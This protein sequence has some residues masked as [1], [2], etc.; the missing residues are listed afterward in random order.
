MVTKNV[1]KSHKIVYYLQLNMKQRIIYLALL[2]LTCSAAFAQSDDAKALQCAAE[3]FSQK[4]HNNG[5][6]R[7]VKKLSH[8]HV[9]KSGDNQFVVVGSDKS[10]R[11]KVIAYSLCNTAGEM[12]DAMIWWLENVNAALEHG[13]TI[14]SVVPGAL[15]PE[16]APLIQTKWNQSAPFNNACPIYI[17]S[18]GTQAPSLTGCVATAMAQVMYYHR[19]PAQYGNGTKT[20]TVHHGDGS[21]STVTVNFATTSFD[22]DN[23]LTDYSNGYNAE[24]ADAVAQLML[25]CGVAANTT[26][27]STSSSALSSNTVYGLKRYLGFENGDYYSNKES[28]PAEEWLRDIYKNISDSF[29]VIYGG[30]NSSNGVHEFV[31]DGYDQNGLV[32]VNWGWGGN[33]DGFFNI[34]LLNPYSS[35]TAGYSNEQFKMVNIYPEN[36]DLENVIEVETPGTLSTLLPE[37]YDKLYPEIKIKGALNSDDVAWIRHL[38]QNVTKTFDFSESSIVEGGEPYFGNLVTVANEFPAH[39][40]DGLSINSI[41]LPQSITAIGDSAFANNV[42]LKNVEIPVGVK[43]IGIGSFA[44]CSGITSFT[45]PSVIETLGDGAFAGCTGI[46]SIAIPVGIERLSDNL[47][48]DCTKLSEVSLSANIKDI[49]DWTFA[50][51]SAI[52]QIELPASLQAIGKAAFFKCTKIAAIN[53]PSSTKQIG[54]SAFYSC[55][56]LQNVTFNEGVQT[57]GSCAFSNCSKLNNVVV[58]NSVTVIGD[59]AFS[60]CSSLSDIQLSNSL[61]TLEWAVLASCALQHINIPE[62]VEIIEGSALSNNNLLELV[63]PNSV[64]DIGR[65]AFTNNRN[66]STLVVGTGLETTFMPFDNLMRPSTLVFNAI[67][68]NEFDMN[69]TQV[70]NLTIG[71]NVETIPSYFMRNNKKFDELTLPASVRKI[72]ANAFNNT[73]LTSIEM[74]QEVDAIGENAFGNCRSLTSFAIPDS[75]EVLASGVLYGSSALEELTLGEGLKEVHTNLSEGLTALKRVNYNAVSM[76]SIQFAKSDKIESITIGQKVKVIPDYFAMNQRLLTSI[77]FPQGLKRI[78]DYAFSCCI[79]I[80][81]I[82]IPHSVEHIG[83]GTFSSTGIKTCR[84]PASEFAMGNDAF[85]GCISLQKMYSYVHPDDIQL[86]VDAIDYA[87][88]SATL[89]VPRRF[90]NAYMNAEQWNV[91]YIQPIDDADVDMDG[92]ITATDITEIYNILLGNIH[93]ASSYGD[94]DGDGTVTATDITVIYNILLGNK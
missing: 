33:Y 10:G 62:S 40:F 59:Y 65:Y 58:P 23:M 35:T 13:A 9:V 74:S 29:P 27:T 57:I 7:V 3:F 87:N 64:K 73:S 68:C 28:I 93:T 47:F 78:G 34:N 83:I 81:S 91:F 20:L 31:L 12:P 48:A 14:K 75:V 54:D 60:A 18:D 76:D 66:L 86:G 90:L 21:T 38:A 53:F 70:T 36:Y 85:Y 43:A 25:A 15:K 72:G 44:G 39:C 11:N 82:D 37:P 17:A 26:Y 5:E 52:T 45:L 77:I 79:N 16:V 32:H 41:T 71:D 63:I 49:G 1:L 46:T 8:L 92:A 50:K 67:N 51:C 61:T 24:Q 55:T 89:Y 56:S 4:A 80:T 88:N 30:I 2:L 69:Y 22:W 42:S 94:V 84:F 6:M 19:C